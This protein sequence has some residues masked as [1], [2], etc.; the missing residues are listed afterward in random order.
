MTAIVRLKIK[1]DNVK[2]SVLRRI[3][4]PRTIRL[5][6][7]HFVIQAAMGWE[8]CHLWEFR[9]G[10]D[11][12]YGIPGPDWPDS[13]PLDAS[14]A[15]LASLLTRMASAK[16]FRYAYDFG[17]NWVHTITVEARGKADPTRS[18]PRLVKAKGRCPPEDCGGP[19][20]YAR[21]LEAIADPDHEEHDDM[22]DWRGVGFDPNTVDEAEIRR[23]LGVIGGVIG[24]SG[25]SG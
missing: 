1:L 18:Y 8:D 15:T 4:A 13:Q 14:E 19:W 7:L 6:D 5:D 17:D 24:E 10:R 22:I 3:E 9:L 21:Y 11:I 12:A 25:D 23:I 2:P 16:T 20:G